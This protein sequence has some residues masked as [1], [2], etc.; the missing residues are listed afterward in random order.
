M[1][2]PL[3]Y[4]SKKVI[5]KVRI[6]IRNGLLLT[7]YTFTYMRWLQQ[8]NYKEAIEE[9]FIGISFFSNPVHE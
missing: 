8:K 7:A 6:R 9:K 5:K 4:N 3:K 2:L 1:G